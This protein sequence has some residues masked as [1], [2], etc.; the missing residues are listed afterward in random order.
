MEY[1]IINNMNDN[2]A[3]E[4]CSWKYNN[5]FQIYNMPKFETAKIKNYSICNPNKS[6]EFFCF[7]NDQN[8]LVGYCR[9]IFKDN[10]FEM[11]IGLSPTW[12]GGGRGGEI[13]NLSINELK[14]NNPSAKIKLQVRSWNIR[15]IKCYQKCG[16][17]IISTKTVLDKSNTPCEFVFMEL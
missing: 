9:F 6:K 1:K 17:K 2:I 7:F 10:Y 14:K 12:I 11:G 13:I 5:E 16:F 3:K 8:I 15:A 4:I